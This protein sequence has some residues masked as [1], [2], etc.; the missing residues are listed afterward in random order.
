M[1]PATPELRACARWL[2]EFADTRMGDVFVWQIFYEAVILPFIFQA[3][4]K[5]TRLG[6]M[7][8]QTPPGSHHAAL[9]NL[10]V[11]LTD[12]TLATVTPRRGPMSLE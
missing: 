12:T 3:L 9:A 1:L 11:P 8:V 10:G 4:A 5:V 2:E 6:E 7:L